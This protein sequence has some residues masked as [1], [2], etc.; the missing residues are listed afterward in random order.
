LAVV[1]DEATQERCAD[2]PK[3]VWLVDIRDETNPIIVGTAP[4]PENA[5]ALCTRGG[6]FGAHNLHPAFPDGLS[7]QLKNTFVGSFFNGGVRIYRLID[8]PLV[9]APPQIKELGY[10]IP[11]AAPGNASGTSQINHII[12]DENGLI[13]AADRLTGGLYILRYTG[14]TPLD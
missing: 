3:L 7:A 8:A 14:K 9:G 5:A 12:V 4:L 1:S 11:A 10:F 13:Y 6:R 2:G